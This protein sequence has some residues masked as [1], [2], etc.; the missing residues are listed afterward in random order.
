LAI[1]MALEVPQAVISAADLSAD[2][3]HVTATNADR[4]GAQITLLQGDL[5]QAVGDH[6]FDVIV[7]NP[8]Y[9]PSTECRE[10]QAEVMREPMM[11]LDGGTDG[12]DF[13]RRIA[14][15]AQSHLDHNGSIL[16]EVGIGEA[17]AVAVMLH[18]NGLT[19][20][21]IHKDLNNIERMVTA[22]R[23]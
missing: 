13:Y 21:R 10:L 6:C 11:A 22:I 8:P 7:S 14:Q 15:G 23:P 19:D 5:W 20:I 2:A 3:L 9:I 1:T 4:L 17:Q 18:E 16:L 12:L